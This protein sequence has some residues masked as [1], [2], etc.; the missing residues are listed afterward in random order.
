[1]EREV[2]REVAHSEVSKLVAMAMFLYSLPAHLADRADTIVVL[3]GQGEKDRLKWAI[4]AWE[5]GKQ[6]RN[7]LVAGVNPEEETWE[8][9]TLESLQKPPYNL[10]TTEGVHI[11]PMADNTKV[12]ADWVAQM[13]REVDVE[14]LLLVAPNYH[15]LRAYLTLL[16]AF[17][18][19]DFNPPAMIPMPL[20]GAPGLQSPETGLT[21]WDICASEIE[22]IRLYQPRG[23]VATATDLQL[24][25]DWLNEIFIRH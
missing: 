4:K 13:I 23:D 8:P 2:P 21:Y 12:Q 25:L 16:A 7:L 17:K 11:Q 10:I 18:R 15:N 1:V 22:R 5:T 9:I 14:C 6:T 19:S 3:P 24:Y 20:W